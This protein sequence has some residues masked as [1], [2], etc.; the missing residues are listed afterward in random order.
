MNRLKVKDEEI[1]RYL[2]GGMS[3]A[4]QVALEEA[5][6]SDPQT[7][8]LVADVENDLIDDYVRSRLEP[9]QR[10]LFERNFLSSP[11]QRQRVEIARALL[12]GLDRT[13]TAREN[14]SAIIENPARRQRFFSFSFI[15]Q[16][17]FR[18]A[19]AVAILLV[20]IGWAWL[21]LENTRLRQELGAAQEEAARRERELGQQVADERQQNTRLVDEIAQ[22]RNR[23]APQITPSALP[24]APAFVTLLLAGALRDPGAG[25]IPQLTVPP[26]AEQVRLVLKM[27]DSG[28]P[29]YRAE[30]QSASGSGILT[31]DNLKPNISRSVATFTV[32]V[33]SD[34]LTAGVYTL[35]LS[36]VRKNGEADILSRSSFRIEKR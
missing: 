10:E 33:P 3:D 21:L 14:H 13:E 16:L 35:T 17:A 7:F 8:T 34:K 36:G 12:P 9:G 30:V 6:V 1:V 24:A 5:F 20:A 2:L 22:L 26:N 25:D 31:Q 28:Y 32:N 18:L 23:S 19:A 15:P 4:E 29:G 11:G 27:E